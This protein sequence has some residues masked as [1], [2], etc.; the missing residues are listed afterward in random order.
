M[1]GYSAGAF[2]ATSAGS[3]AR[4]NN[5]S[6]TSDD[7]RPVTSAGIRG[8]GLRPPTPLSHGAGSRQGAQSAVGWEG[9]GGFGGSGTAERFFH[10]I[11]RSPRLGAGGGNLS[12]T[13][14]L[15][16]AKDW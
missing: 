12:G 7:V 13:Q 4:R 1:S 5:K 16:N 9:T 10:K 6:G 11:P 14:H 15:A 3:L 2:S 8:H